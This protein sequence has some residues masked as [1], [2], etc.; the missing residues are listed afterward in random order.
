V[1][2][3]RLPLTVIG[4]YLGAGKTTLIN[5]LLADPKGQRLMV[6]VN[7][8]GSINIDA[9][10]L[11][12]ADEDTLT[13]TNGCVCCTMGADLFMA[14]SDVLDRKPRPDHLIIEASGVADPSKI[15]T[16]AKAEKDMRYGGIITVVDAGNFPNLATDPMIGEQIKAQTACADLLLISKTD[17]IPASLRA[18]LS[19]LN[20]A[21]QL[22]ANKVHSVADLLITPWGNPG[23]LPLAKPHP[24]YVHWTR[25]CSTQFSRNGL[26]GLLAERP[27]GLFRLKGFVRGDDGRGFLVQ[28]VGS[29][30]SITRM[31]QPAETALVGIGLKDRVTQAE[32]DR[33]WLG[34]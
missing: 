34:D 9:A 20:G 3:E 23:A 31:D 17:E 32:C 25:S 28:G 30:V 13:L 18:Q 19:A 6:L 7:D 27:T 10:L 26:R 8:F 5:K 22:L 24:D 29:S 11:E 12:S 21:D 2:D 1:K 16:A 15:A 33:W 14:I 4:G